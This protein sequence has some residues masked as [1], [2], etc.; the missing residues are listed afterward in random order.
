MQFVILVYHMTAGSTRIPIY[1][2]VRVLV[3][4]YLFLNGY[5]HFMYFWNKGDVSAYRF[6]QIVFRM[7]LLVFCLCIV[8][9]R[10]YQFYYFV[11]PFLHRDMYSMATYRTSKHSDKTFERQVD[12]QADKQADKR[13]GAPRD[14]QTGW[15]ADKLIDK[16]TN[17]QTETIR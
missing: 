13:M 17:G 16:H 8:M 15:Q 3:S 14:T 2:S 9:H 4:S 10:Q 7:N 11:S 12:R 6:F 1:M 5:A